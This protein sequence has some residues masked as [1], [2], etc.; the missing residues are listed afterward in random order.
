MIKN[1]LL[2]GANGQLGSEIQKLAPFY[3]DFKLFPTDVDSLNICLQDEVSRFLD[4][5]RIDCIV[6]CAAYTAVDRA[7]SDVARCFAINRDAVANLA[8]AA[9]GKAKIV[10]I[11]TDYVFDGNGDRPLKET[12]AVNPQSV[13]GESKL[14]GERALTEIVPD[15]SIIIRTAWLYSSFG[16][17][18]VKTI[19]RLGSERDTIRVVS[20]QRGTPTYAADLADAIFRSLAFINGNGAFSAGVYH[21]TDEGECTWFDFAQKTHSIAGIST[22]RIVP[23]STVEYPTAARRP[24]YSVLDKTKISA[25]FNLSIPAWEES[26]ARCVEILKNNI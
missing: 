19:L 9:A 16:S 25:T 20:D 17:N 24:A 12:D 8:R 3:P 5:N 11:S 22:C 23:V 10:H 18:F 13:Y 21:F 15:G 1:I 6:N 2:T 14:A 4:E 26:L 7:E